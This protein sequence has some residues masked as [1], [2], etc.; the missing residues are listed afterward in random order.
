VSVY[1]QAT[2]EEAWGQMVE[3]QVAAIERDIV[4]FINGLLDDIEAWMKAEARW[5][6]R[7]GDARANLY[8]DIIHVANESVTVLVSHG[9]A[10]NYAL[11]LELNPRY[12]I[13]ADTIDHWAPVVFQGVQEIV[14]RHTGG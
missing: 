12:A 9:P 6:D 1:W 2:P 4:A 3:A 13:I 5:T 14:R 11:F 10:I 8:S 7:T